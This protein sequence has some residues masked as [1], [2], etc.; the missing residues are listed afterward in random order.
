[1]ADWKGS[2][3]QSDI[4][5]LSF[6]QHQI[7]CAFIL[8]LCCR[9]YKN[10]YGLLILSLGNPDL[11][12]FCYASLKIIYMK[13]NTFF[14]SSLILHLFLLLNFLEHSFFTNLAKDICG[15]I[16]N[17]HLIPWLQGIW[18]HP[19]FSSLWS[20]QNLFSRKLI[21]IQLS[22]NYT[23]RHGKASRTRCRPRLAS[24]CP[25]KYAVPREKASATQRQAMAQIHWQQ[26][27]IC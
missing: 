22:E 3:F 27:A 1:M 2:Y 5:F 21:F 18:N 9:H 16:S 24:P 14:V 26:N 12:F 20:S 19:L 8:F 4:H 23:K 15:C 13:M 17:H 7:T 25:E 10:W 11:S 6:L